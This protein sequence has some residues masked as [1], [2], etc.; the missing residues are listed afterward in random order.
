MIPYE[1]L[2]QAIDRWRARAAGVEEPAAAV[3]AAAPAY[4]PAAYAPGPEYEEPVEDGATPT[5][6]R[7]ENTNEIDI[8][9]LDVVE[10]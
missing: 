6:V 2:C 3:A 1:E 4:A 8:D 9:S 5:P 7:Q 10:G